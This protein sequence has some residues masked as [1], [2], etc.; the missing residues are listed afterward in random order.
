M[1]LETLP[2]VRYHEEKKG[3]AITIWLNKEEREQLEKAKL[4]LE[5]E[6]DSTAFKQAAALG[7]EILIGDPKTAT[8]LGIVFKNKRNNKRLGIATFE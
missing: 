6:R 4:V 7:F 8:L 1:P 2:F 3:D 5:Q